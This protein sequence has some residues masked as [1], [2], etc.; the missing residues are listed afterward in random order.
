M[1]PF[2]EA[3]LGYTWAMLWQST[4]V[5]VVIWLLYVLSWKQSAAFRY[6]LLCLILLKFLLPT[7]LESLIGVRHLWGGVEQRITTQFPAAAQL[8]GTRSY[9]ITPIQEGGTHIEATRFPVEPWLVPSLETRYQ[10]PTT[11]LLMWLGGVLFLATLLL[12]YALRVRRRFSAA[13]KVE[14]FRVLAFLEECRVGLRVSRP[15]P[16]YQLAGLSSPVLSGLLHPRILISPDTLSR[17]SESHLRPI[18]L[19]ELAHAKRCDLWINLLQIAL[20]V[21]WFFHPGLWLTNWLIRSERERACDDLVLASMGHAGRDYADSILEVLKG[22][23]QPRWSAVGL[24]GIAEGGKAIR[25]R[26]M[27]ILDTKRK[28]QLRIGILRLSLLVL[29]GAVILPMAPGENLLT[30]TESASKH[31]YTLDDLTTLVRASMAKIRN[32]S[33][34]YRFKIIFMESNGK[35]DQTTEGWSNVKTIK[36]D[37]RRRA[38]YHYRTEFNGK[39]HNEKAIYLYNDKLPGIAKYWCDHVISILAEKPHG[40]TEFPRFDV[41]FFQVRGT[42]EGLSPNE[43]G[44]LFPQEFYIVNQVEENND[45]LVIVSIS[46]SKYENLGLKIWVNM[47]Q[48]AMPVH[49]VLSE[50]GQVCEDTITDWKELGVGEWIPAQV[51]YKEYRFSDDLKERYLGEVAEYH[52]ENGEVNIEFPPETFTLQ[53]LGAPKGTFVVDHMRDQTWGG[54]VEY[55]YDGGDYNPLAE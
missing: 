1:T 9:D 4:L 47:K 20:Q 15:I 3:W 25:G 26:I 36:G 24:L 52:L 10:L 32:R 19:H 38:E 51:T 41:Y 7:S 33:L 53:G 42:W 39:G 30:P 43:D 27:R 2:S 44:P 5:M 23:V 45:G 29:L 40:E 12:I 8:T 49:V 13:V 16:L 37:K 21:L 50:D 6:A 17:L 11:L 48:G 46:S 31:S 22:S 54:G 35:I 18:F 14:D 55:L 34:T 28:V